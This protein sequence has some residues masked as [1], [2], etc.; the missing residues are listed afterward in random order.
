VNHITAADAIEAAA[1]TRTARTDITTTARTDTETDHARMN[2]DMGTKDTATVTTR[3]KI[4][5][6][7]NDTAKD[8]AVDRPDATRSRKRK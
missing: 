5:A 1:E 6:A 2:E 7:G 3:T 4:A 8:I